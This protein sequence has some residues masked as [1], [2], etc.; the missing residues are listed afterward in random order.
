LLV[1][2]SGILRFAIDSSRLAGLR[3]IVPEGYESIRQQTIPL[4]TAFTPEEP[5]DVSEWNLPIVYDGEISR[6]L[7]GSLQRIR[8]NGRVTSYQELHTQLRRRDLPS[9]LQLS[10]IDSSPSELTPADIY[11]LRKDAVVVIGQLGDDG[12][13]HTAGGVV[14]SR[15]GAI[16]TAYHVLNKGPSIVARGVRTADGAVHPIEEVLVADRAA[17]VAIVRIGAEDL[18]PAPISGGD[19]VGAPVTMISHPAG[20]FFTLTQG[21]ISR[22]SA[23]ILFGR[24]T[25]T[26]AV[27]VEFADGA[28]GGPIFN[29]RGEVCG[30]VSSTNAQSDQMVMRNAVPSMAILRLLETDTTTIER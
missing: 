4:G 10:E 5:L 7:A 24:P 18:E 8:M 9:P 14:I 30:L 27:T 20:Q 16:A 3:L 23:T 15:T 22:Y 25:V 11:R 13:L 19:P 6:N 17:D 12:K 21:C 28:S 29:R 1:G 26:M 2:K